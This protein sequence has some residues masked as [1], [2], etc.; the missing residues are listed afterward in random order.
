MKK[1]LVGL[2]GSSRERGILDAAI[3]LARKTGAKLVLFRCVGLP[4]GLPPEAYSMPPQDVPKMLEE[5]AL[6]ALKKLEQGVPAET[7][8]GVSV[9]V[10]SPWQS[11]DRAAKE[12]DVDLVVIGSHGFSGLDHVIG[13]TA[14]KVVNHADRAVLVVRAAERLA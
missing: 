14:A 12:H 10:G 7:R 8:G 4:D 9:H 5:H 3:A 1:I 13:T 11:I 2:D 6:A